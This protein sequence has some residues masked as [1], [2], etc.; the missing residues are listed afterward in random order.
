ML[1]FTVQLMGFQH[2]ICTDK[3]IWF[4]KHSSLHLTTT[5]PITYSFLKDMDTYK[6][7]TRNLTCVYGCYDAELYLKVSLVLVF[8]LFMPTD[9]VHALYWKFKEKKW[10]KKKPK[11]KLP[12]N[13]RLK[14]Y[15][16]LWWVFNRI[17]VISCYSNAYKLLKKWLG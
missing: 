4:V 8:F 3:F 9:I 6:N 2:L 1:W 11:M 14:C 12:I 15:G 16:I 10:K 17:D 5:F 13:L 7:L